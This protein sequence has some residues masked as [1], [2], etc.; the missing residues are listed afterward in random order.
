VMNEHLRGRDDLVLR[1]ANAVWVD[2]SETLQ[3]EFKRRAA[4]EY[5]A[6]VREIP[7]KLPE[8]VALVN[9]W[10]DSTTSGMIPSVR[11]KPFPDTISVVLSNAVYLKST[12]LR[13][14]DPRQTKERPFTLSGKRRSRPAMESTSTLGYRRGKNYQAIRLPYKAG[15]TALYLVLPDSGRSALEVLDVISAT[16]WP[17][18]DGRKDG[19][20]VHLVVPTVHV[21]QATDLIP[22]LGRLGMGIAFDWRRADFSGLVEPRPDRLPECPPLS[23]MGARGRTDCTV[24]LITGASQNVYFDMNEE[25]TEAAAVTVVELSAVDALPPPPIPFVV[26]RPFLFMLRDERT[27]ASLFVGYVADPTPAP[28]ASVSRPV[29]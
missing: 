2:T 6:A 23:Q 27:G 13:P 19:R 17:L 29:N 11:E 4:R 7:L 16:G 15:L 1:L 14:F 8:G 10:A 22:P 5:D 26:D 9:R 24:H 25:G 20:E 12:W 28:N 18:P 21:E 3:P